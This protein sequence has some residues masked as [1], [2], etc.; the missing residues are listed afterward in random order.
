MAPAVSRPR[1]SNQ[2]DQGKRV[3]RTNQDFLRISGI[4]A[5]R[6]HKLRHGGFFR[7]F[8][9]SSIWLNLPKVMAATAWEEPAP[10]MLPAGCREARRRDRHV[11]HARRLQS[12]LSQAIG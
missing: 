7:T 1:R 4:D 11:N 5:E 2:R 8:G 6:K 10:T 12:K 9:V 3:L